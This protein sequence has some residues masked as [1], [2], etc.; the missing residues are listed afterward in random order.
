MHNSSPILSVAAAGAFNA[1]TDATRFDDRFGYCGYDLYNTI[2]MR[3]ITEY[4][5]GEVFDTDIVILCFRGVLK[6]DWLLNIPEIK[7]ASRSS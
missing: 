1:L 7:F 2:S 6:P 3:F 4:I 5:P